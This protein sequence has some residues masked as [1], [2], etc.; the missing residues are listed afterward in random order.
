[1]YNNYI[2]ISQWFSIAHSVRVEEISNGVKIIE[3]IDGI[4]V[5]KE[6][7]ANSKLFIRATNEDLFP[8]NTYQ[9]IDVIGEIY[10]LPA[11]PNEFILVDSNNTEYISS[12]GLELIENSLNL[13]PFAIIDLTGYATETFV[14]QAISSAISNIKDNTQEFPT[15]QDFPQPGEVGNIYIDLEEDVLYIWDSASNSYI[16][17]S[18]NQTI[19]TGIQTQITSLQNSKLDKGGYVG[20]AQD[21]YNRFEGKIVAGY[22]SI[23]KVGNGASGK[24]MENSIISETNGK[25]GIALGVEASEKLDVG[26]RVKSDG[27][28]LNDTTSAILPREIKFKDGKIKAALADGVEKAVL[29]EGDV[30]NNILRNLQS[31]NI[32][33]CGFAPFGSA[34][35][36]AVWTVTK[37]TVAANGSITKQKFTNVTWSSVP[38]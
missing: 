27:L 24:V 20:T 12:N 30:Q 33:F 5:E 4:I 34:E 1:M 9:I 23:P 13:K 8:T 11:F 28:V 2:G 29:L 10:N 18:W 32:N 19:I 3:N 16:S 15:F 21:L 36:A 6:V 22:N 37:I 17:Q 25:I 14:S 7:S 38:F 26:G 31:N 35:N